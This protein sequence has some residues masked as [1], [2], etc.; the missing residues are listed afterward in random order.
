MLNNILFGCLNRFYKR[1]KSEARICNCKLEDMTDNAE[2]ESSANVDLVCALCD[3]GGEI[4][5]CTSFSLLLDNFYIQQT[6]IVPAFRNSWSLLPTFILVI[7]HFLSSY[8]NCLQFWLWIYFINS[9]R[10]YILDF[11]SLQLSVHQGL[12]F[13]EFRLDFFNPLWIWPKFIQIQSKL[14]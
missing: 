7:K 14:V 12:K 9:K 3:N 4:V 11:L 5:R 1:H 6:D 2:G 8:R 13:G 10:S